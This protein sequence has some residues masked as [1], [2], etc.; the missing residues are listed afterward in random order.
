MRGLAR[1][2]LRRKLNRPV[3]NPRV[4]QIEAT[5]QVR[6]GRR[7]DST[8]E[9][10]WMDLSEPGDSSGR[11]DETNQRGFPRGQRFSSMDELPF[12]ADYP[13]SAGWRNM[14]VC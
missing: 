6:A 11:P 13:P 4:A 2:S 14:L 8:R 7:S 5:I 12:L 10:A 3:A 9:I 1:L